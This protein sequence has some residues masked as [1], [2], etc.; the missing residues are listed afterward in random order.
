[1]TDG[2]KPR[3]HHSEQHHCSMSTCACRGDGPCCP[4]PGLTPG[5]VPPRQAHRTCCGPRLRSC[6][7]LRGR[8]RRWGM[9]EDA[10]RASATRDGWNAAS[11]G[12]TRIQRMRNNLPPSS[13][14]KHNFLD[15][16]NIRAHRAF[17]GRAPFA[18]P[19]PVCKKRRQKRCLQCDMR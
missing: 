10:V 9:Q 17:E 11:K 19:H 13:A 4:L 8:V 15:Q 7:R 18:V 16:E 1:M 6:R 14:N 5:P 12:S 3:C 2:R